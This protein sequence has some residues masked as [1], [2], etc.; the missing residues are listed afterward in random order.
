MSSLTLRRI[1]VVIV[2]QA[3]GFVL[4]YLLITVGFSLLPLFSSIETSQ[5][6]TIA[7]Y[8]NLYFAAT[9]IPI[10]IIVM[11][12]LDALMDTKILPD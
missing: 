12:W 11:I 1:L 8:G 7:E 2:S 9:F 6:R 10:G 4:G 5:S 3:I